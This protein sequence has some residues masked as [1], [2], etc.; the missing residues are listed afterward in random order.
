MENLRAP[1]SQAF[2]LRAKIKVSNGKGASQEGE[3]GLNWWSGERWQESLKIG[4]F[5]RG[6]EGVKD[7]YWQSRLEDFQPEGI[8][9]F[10]R[11]L[12][13]ADTLKLGVE[14]Y[15]G[16]V[17]TDKNH[18][19]PLSCVAVN[20]KKN[21]ARTLCFE[22]STGKLAHVKIGFSPLNGGGRTIDYSDFMPLGEKQFPGK[23]TI[24]AKDGETVEISV[25]KL[26]PL[27]SPAPADVAKGANSE[28]WRACDDAVEPTLDTQVQPKYPDE[29]KWNH[30]QGQVT[31]Y[32]RIE[33]DGT[34]SHLRVL[35]SPF[36]RLSQGSMDAVSRWKYKPAK[37]GD[38][39]IPRETM[40][41]VIYTLGD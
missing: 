22:Q 6:R 27:T 26:A 8:F 20:W 34:V 39:P 18:G 40:T 38:T 5:G 4:E 32:M 36:P 12:N 1:G 37:C 11:A 35:S 29:S 14:E 15:W 3:Y 17:S 28:F 23:I 21:L 30:E 24:T 13:L 19:D 33:A 10:D 31:M 41:T 7:G 2:L 16:K 9:D 25:T